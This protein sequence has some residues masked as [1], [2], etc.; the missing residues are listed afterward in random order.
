MKMRIGKFALTGLMVATVA[1]A[2]DDANL[3]N[4]ARI[5]Q[6]KKEANEKELTDKAMRLYIKGPAYE[7]ADVPDNTYSDGPDAAR[8]E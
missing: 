2:K 4:I 1:S 6:L 8:P 3:E 7:S 5:E